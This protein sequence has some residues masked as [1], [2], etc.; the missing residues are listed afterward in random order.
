VTNK[1]E[2]AQYSPDD[3]RAIWDFGHQDFENFLEL[4]GW[5][6]T[7]SSKDRDQQLTAA[8]S[9]AKLD[10][11]AS[12]KPRKARKKGAGHESL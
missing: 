3:L 10:N 7:L 5:L 11:V 4:L 8:Q 12:G 6:E 1:L 9:L 2:I